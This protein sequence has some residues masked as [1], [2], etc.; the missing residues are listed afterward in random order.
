ML[1][2]YIVDLKG[3]VDL[4]LEQAVQSPCLSQR[5]VS[6]L[7]SEK[8]P[9]AGGFNHPPAPFVCDRSVECNES[10]G[11]TAVHAE[12]SAIL[13]AR[14]D[15][16]GGFLLH[17]KAKEGR[18]CASMAPSCLE[19]SKLILEA[20]IEWVHLVHE[21]VAQLLAGA[22]TVGWTEGFHWD[23]TLGPL[24]VRRYSAAQFH[25]LTAVCRRHGVRVRLK[26]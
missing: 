25:R 21:P 9:V 10:C 11:L 16:R 6:I 5:G 1:D 15:L 8:R 7:N 20:G 13:A 3:W 17:V 2:T 22:E 23:G 19:C 4:A 14:V 26:E 24:H 18:P 12:Q